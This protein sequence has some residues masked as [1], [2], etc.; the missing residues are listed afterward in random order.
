[1]K[2]IETSLPGVWILEPEVFGDER[3]FLF[4]SFHAQRWATLGCTNQWVQENQSHSRRGV[5]RG[6][7]YQWPHPQAKL[8][9]VAAGAVFDVAVDVR[10]NSPHFG[11]WT[12]VMLSS[13]NKRQLYIPRGFAHGFLTLSASADFLY[14]C[15]EYYHPADEHGIAWDDP[16]IGIAWPIPPDLELLLSERDR[17]YPPLAEVEPAALPAG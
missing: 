6:L 13:E 16:Q 8:C 1:M 14:K 15:D 11:Q 7:H 10:R 9:R 12:G 2:K 3:G 17:R 5:L 4:E